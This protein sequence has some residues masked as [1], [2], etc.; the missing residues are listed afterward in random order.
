MTC[1]RRGRCLL[2][3]RVETRATV[4]SDDKRETR[5][6]AVDDGARDTIEWLLLATTN[7]K[8]GRGMMLIT[9]RETRATAAETQPWNACVTFST[10]LAR[11][12]QML[13]LLK[14]N[15]KHRCCLDS[16]QTITLD[17]ATARRTRHRNVGVRHGSRSRY[18]AVTRRV[19]RSE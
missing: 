4:A 19:Q 3:A 2:F 16:L 15:E 18:F 10:L 11:Q 6:F 8:H 7:V 14:M 1:I 17:S 9:T 12:V 5:V 13:V